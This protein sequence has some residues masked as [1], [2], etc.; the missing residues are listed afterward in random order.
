MKLRLGIEDYKRHVERHSDQRISFELRSDSYWRQ[1]CFHDSLIR[2]RLL[3]EQNFKCIETI[4]LLGTARYLFEVVVWI[5]LMRDEPNYGLV[6]YRSWSETNRKYWN[7]TRNQ[8]LREIS[9]LKGFAR[10]EDAARLAGKE[11][12][13]SS[14]DATSQAAVEVDRKAAR[15]FSIYCEQ[16]MKS[17]GYNFQAHLLETKVLP[18]LNERVTESEV[19]C[20][21]SK[22][23]LPVDV[24]KVA[25]NWNWKDQ[26]NRVGLGEA[27]CVNDFETPWLRN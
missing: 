15:M 13:L 3:I 1:I 4:A 26:A 24:I 16:A 27:E 20:D 10:D 9:M 21:A 25:A 22:R 11:R 14:F 8:V 19:A 2:L 18:E 7:D 6:Y 12:G 5:K 17:N 23:A